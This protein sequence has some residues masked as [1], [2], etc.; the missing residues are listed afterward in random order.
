M[1]EIGLILMAIDSYIL[2]LLIPPLV[3]RVPHALF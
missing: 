1:A 2:P 3:H